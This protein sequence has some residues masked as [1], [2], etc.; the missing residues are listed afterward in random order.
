MLLTVSVPAS[1]AA[2]SDGYF[3]GIDMDPVGSAVI[4]TVEQEPAVALLFAIDQDTA[5]VT[6]QFDAWYQGERPDITVFAIAVAPEGISQEVALEALEQ[7]KLT[8]PVFLAGSD[9]LLGES[10]RVVVL[11]D[12]MEIARFQSLDVSGVY[13]TLEQIGVEVP[14][15]PAASVEPTTQTAEASTTVTQPSRQGMLRVNEYDPPAPATTA[16]TES[17]PP[18]EELILGGEGQPGDYKNNIYG[19]EVTFPPNWRFRVAGRRDGAVAIPPR[20]SQIDLRIWAMPANGL[21]SPQSYVNQRLEAIGQ[22]SRTP[23]RVERQTAIIRDGG[24][25]I[26]ITYAYTRPLDAAGPGRSVLW[27]GRMLVVLHGRYIKVAGATAP[28]AEFLASAPLIDS[29]IR[30]FQVLQHDNFPSSEYLDDNFI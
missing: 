23:V 27:R 24:Q 6:Q 29:F 5:E 30:S 3:Y 10:Y 2:P 4:E 26:D 28:N 16:P 13:Q 19:M 11:N 25:S 9:V 22:R 18:N 7:R 15:I 1:A 12:D 14:E 20:G 8:M 17:S 21:A